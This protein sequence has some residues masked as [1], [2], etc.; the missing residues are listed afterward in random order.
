[1]LHYR[2]PCISKSCKQ[3]EHN[4]NYIN[5]N[6]FVLANLKNKQNYTSLTKLMVMNLKFCAQNH[7]SKDDEF[8]IIKYFRKNNPSSC[9]TWKPSNFECLGLSSLFLCEFWDPSFSGK[10]FAKMGWALNCL[11]WHSRVCVGLRNQ[12]MRLNHLG[13]GATIPSI[14]RRGQITRLTVQITKI[15]DYESFM[16]QL[17]NL[18][19]NPRVITS[20]QG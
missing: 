11:G 20:N 14:Q 3:E 10:N 5:I 15:T 13:H 19:H 17:C 8:Y 9:K 12:K 16:A 6:V 18:F 4:I 2:H 7:C 1:M